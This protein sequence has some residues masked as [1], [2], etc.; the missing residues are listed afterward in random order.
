MVHEQ[1]P[2]SQSL[3]QSPQNIIPPNL[4]M[5]PSFHVRHKLGARIRG[6]PPV[7]SVHDCEKVCLY[8]YRPDILSDIPNLVSVF[9]H[10]CLHNVYPHAAVLHICCR[11]G[12]AGTFLCTVT[13]LL[14]RM[15]VSMGLLGRAG[16]HRGTDLFV[17]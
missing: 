17:C 1:S 5:P 12:R 13:P 10:V 9:M 2:N 8:M 3:N 15:Y 11:H 14:A 7:H 4:S 16:L 6:F